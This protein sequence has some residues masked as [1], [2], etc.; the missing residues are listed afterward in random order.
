MP[1][2]I[3]RGDEWDDDSDLGEDDDSPDFGDDEPMI[4]CP[5]CG[6]DI[7]DETERC[8]HCGQYISKRTRLT[9]ASPGGSS[10]A[11]WCACTWT[12]AGTSGGE[13][14]RL[15][16]VAWPE[17]PDNDSRSADLDF[18]AAPLHC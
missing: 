3:N 18:H 14:M 17:H 11:W 13:L 16:E 5:Y 6:V 2:V 12:T 10:S 4:P 7:H 8:S 15:P 9:S 1:R